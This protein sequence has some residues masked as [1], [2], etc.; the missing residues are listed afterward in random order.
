M[1]SRRPASQPPLT[2]LNSLPSAAGIW[3]ASLT[4]RCSK[5]CLTGL[6]QCFRVLPPPHY[7]IFLPPI[8]L[9]LLKAEA[10]LSFVSSE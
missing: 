2:R 8:T 3:Q 6:C 1:C 10:V 9:Y 4:H 5:Y 7:F